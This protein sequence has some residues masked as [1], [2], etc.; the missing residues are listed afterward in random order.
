MMN[1]KAL[2]IPGDRK[3]ANYQPPAAPPGSDMQVMMQIIERCLREPSFDPDRIQ[4]MLELRERWEANEA[5]KAFHDAMASFKADPPKIYKNKHVSFP[6]GQGGTTEYDHATHSEV[7]EK[8]A[9]AMGPHGL[10]FRWNVEQK[11][12]LIKVTCIVTHRLGHSDSVSL[13]AAPD[14][15]GKKSPIQQVASTITLLQRYTLIAATGMTAADLPD[16]DDRT[17]E[18]GGSGASELITEKQ[19]ADLRALLTEINTNEPSFLRV[20]K[21]DKLENV[22]ASSYPMVLGLLEAKRKNQ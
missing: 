15:S 19:V 5:R 22:L 3:P 1:D 4:K 14:D 20:I 18:H 13:T 2:I 10:S 16:A 21:V 7:V 8:V 11:E 6:S 9:A 17:E 12:G